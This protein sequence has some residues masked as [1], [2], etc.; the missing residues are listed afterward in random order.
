ML[1]VDYRRL[2]LRP[3]DT[4]LDVGAGA[5]RHAFEGLRRGADVVALDLDD[6]SL[7]DAAALMWAMIDQGESPKGAGAM[8][9]VGS[10]LELPFP[11]GSF[12]RIIASE[13]ME[14]IDDDRGAIRELVRVLRPGGRLAVTVPRWFP[15]LVNW[16]LSDE[17]HAPAQPGGHVRIYRESALRGRLE[18]AGLRVVDRH[19]AHGL[20]SPY[21]WLRCAVG[22]HND[23][24]PLVKAYHSMLVWEITARPVPLQLAERVL[25]PAIG[26]SL[27]LYAERTA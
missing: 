12:D 13:V 23:Q 17:Y 8:A 24:H 15:E 22:P 18:D 14:H 4:L 20:H 10:A 26:K 6:A 11:D 27:I 16:A 21:W 2:G 9:T 1:T 7:K 19:H 25:Q 3:G 5:G